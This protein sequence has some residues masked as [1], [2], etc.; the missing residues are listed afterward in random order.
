MDNSQG[1]GHGE[2][3]RLLLTT[4]RGQTSGQHEGCR[5][6]APNVY[7]WAWSGSVREAADL[8]ESFSPGE[9]RRLVAGKNLFSFFTHWKWGCK[10]SQL[11]T[12][13]CWGMLWR[14]QERALIQAVLHRRQDDTYDVYVKPKRNSNDWL[15]ATRL[16]QVVTWSTFSFVLFVI[17]MWNTVV[18]KPVKHQHESHSLFT[19]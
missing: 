3:K 10:P 13:D 12:A 19:R 18:I 7:P 15:P 16:I 8:R 9:S 1:C 4:V 5:C 11:L 17:K 14:M 6:F 2:T